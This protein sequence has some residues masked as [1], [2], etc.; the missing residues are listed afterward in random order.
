MWLR[1]LVDQHHDQVVTHLLMSMRTLIY[2]SVVWVTTSN[3]LLDKVINH[4]QVDLVLVQEVTEHKVK[5]NHVISSKQHI[6]SKYGMSEVSVDL[7]PH[8]K[9]M[10]QSFWG[11][12]HSIQVESLELPFD[13]RSLSYSN[14]VKLHW[15]SSSFAKKVTTNRKAKYINTVCLPRLKKFTC[16]NKVYGLFGR[17]SRP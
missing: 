8:G 13:S 1:E 17:N 4:N 16:I 7:S 15:H 2:R 10:H 12:T 9:W 3:T 11:T 6:Q 5:Y 14:F